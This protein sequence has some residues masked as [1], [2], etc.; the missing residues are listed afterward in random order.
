MSN[1]VEKLEPAEIAPMT[2]VI[3]RIASDPNIPMEPL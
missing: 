3:E 2:D 1:A